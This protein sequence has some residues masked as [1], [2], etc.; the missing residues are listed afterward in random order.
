MARPVG[1]AGVDD[2]PAFRPQ[3]VRHPG[4]FP[5]EPGPFD[6]LSEELGETADARL[7]DALRHVHHDQRRLLR[8]DLVNTCVRHRGRFLRT[9][10]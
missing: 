8:V 10:T 6:R 5:D 9:G 3:A 2:D 7:H 4:N 1:D